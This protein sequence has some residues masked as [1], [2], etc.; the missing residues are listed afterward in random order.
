MKGSAT[1]DAGQGGAGEADPGEARQGDEGA[2]K[3]GEWR[4]GANG[5]ECYFLSSLL[6]FPR[7]AW[8]WRRQQQ[9]QQQQ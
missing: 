5:K 9:Q 7:L 4:C 1:G 6:H 8:R 2:V 3:Y